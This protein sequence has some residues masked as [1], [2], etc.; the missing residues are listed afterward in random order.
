MSAWSRE[1]S[2]FQNQSIHHAWSHAHTIRP[3]AGS[4][5]SQEPVVGQKELWCHVKSRPNRGREPIAGKALGG[6]LRS[7]IAFSPHWHRGRQTRTAF[8]EHHVPSTPQSWY[9]SPDGTP[10]LAR[11]RAMTFLSQGKVQDNFVIGT[12]LFHDCLGWM[13]GFLAFSEGGLLQHNRQ[14]ID[15]NFL[16]NPAAPELCQ[17]YNWRSLSARELQN[18]SDHCCTRHWRFDRS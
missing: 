9:H 7:W 15:R 18:C 11:P 1:A 16:H 2:L 4:F 10:V 5:H 13:C 6:C 8:E 12:M 14:A 3:Q 17:R